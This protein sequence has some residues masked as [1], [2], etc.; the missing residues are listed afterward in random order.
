MIVYLDFRHQKKEII[1]PPQE[2][3]PPPGGN[4][5]PTDNIS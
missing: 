5:F 2:S 4:V 1:L 3:I